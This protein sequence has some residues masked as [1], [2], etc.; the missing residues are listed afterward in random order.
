MLKLT[1]LLQYININ[2][3]IIEKNYFPN[4]YTLDEKQDHNSNIN[5]INNT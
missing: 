2:A 5:N 3:K 4:D 1:I